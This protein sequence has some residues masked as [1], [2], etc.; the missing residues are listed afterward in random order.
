MK[1]GSS[2]L[3]AKG[4]EKSISLAKK[5]RSWEDE[6]EDEIERKG[7]NE[8]IASV[9]REDEEVEDDEE[10]RE[11]IRVEDEESE[12]EVG[13]LQEV[14]NLILHQLVISY[15]LSKVTQHVVDRVL[16]HLSREEKMERSLKKVEEVLLDVSDRV[17]EG[18][19]TLLKVGIVL[20]LI[21]QVLIFVLL[22]LRH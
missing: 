5:E 11:S 4:A 19:S 22:I 16:N 12:I 17:G 14:K 3:G 6:W 1:K 9:I 8:M 7:T 20:T 2:V 10:E 18:S 13:S 21:L 15:N